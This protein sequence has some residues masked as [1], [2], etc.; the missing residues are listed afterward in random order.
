M[1]K[2]ILVFA[3]LLP[4][5]GLAQQY[6]IDWYKVAG[7][8][9]TSSNGQYA[10]SGTVGQHDAGGPLTGGQYSLTG[11]F[12]SII[13]VVQAAGRP[14]LSIRQSGNYVIVSWPDTGDYILQ[15]NNNPGV[16]SGWTTSGYSVSTNNGTDSITIALPSGNLPL[17]TANLFFRLVNP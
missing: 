4:A 6:T 5:G 16:P 14:R 7:G 10:V 11:G 1:K 3:L 13:G 12:W 15:Q 8:G 2:Y 9:G 17:P